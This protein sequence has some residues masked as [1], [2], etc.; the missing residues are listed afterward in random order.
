MQRTLTSEEN[1]VGKQQFEACCNSHEVTVDAYHA[2][3]SR[4]ADNHFINNVQ[5]QSQTITYCGVGAHYQNGI[6]D[7]IIRDITEQA[8]N[9]LL[10]ACSRWPGAVTTALWPY[11]VRQAQDV[12]NYLPM[13]DQGH[14]PIK[15]FFGTD[16][17]PRLGKFHIFGCP[18]FTLEK[19]LQSKQSVPCWDTRDRLGIYLG[20]SPMDARNVS[21][22][23]STSSGCVLPQF[24]VIHD[25]FF[26]TV[27]RDMLTKDVTIK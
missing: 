25:D 17:A 27:Q 23:L 9:M 4:F 19:R 6:D 13:N 18:I 11:A 16:V 24:H 2:D 12:S 21:N 3:K 22:V 1:L 5:K 8:R 26:E 10:H 14:S 20:K 15:R 7:K